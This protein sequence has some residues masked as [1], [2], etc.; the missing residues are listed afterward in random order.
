M[1]EGGVE[2]GAVV[3]GGDDGEVVGLEESYEAVAEEGEVF[4]DDNA[5]GISRVMMVGPPG[6]LVMFMV[7]SKA[8][9]R[10]AM[11]LRPLSGVGWAPPW[12]LSVTVVMRRWRPWLMWIRAWVAPECLA[13]L[14]RSSAMAK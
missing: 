10:R 7:P 1:G 13:V 5:H 9:R 6:G 3:D 11:P 14:V 2:V 8:S 12:P 4:G